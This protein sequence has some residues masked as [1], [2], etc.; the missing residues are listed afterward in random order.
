MKRIPPFMLILIASTLLLGGCAAREADSGSSLSLMERYHS[1]K[2]LLPDDDEAETTGDAKAEARQHLMRGL[3]FMAQDKEEL[4]FEQFSRAAALDNQLTQARFQRGLLLHRQGLQQD[5]LADMEAVLALEPAHAQACEVSG[6]IYFKAGLMDEAL[7]MF[8]KA[9]RLNPELTNSY[10]FI[11]ANRNYRKEHE[12]AFQTLETALSQHPAS[13]TLHNNMGMTLSM[14][15]R[16]A[17]A[18][19]HFRLAVRLG[20][21]AEKTWNNMGLALCRLNRLD[22]ALIAFRNAG[23]EASAHNNVGYYLFLQGRY[24]EAVI[25]LEKAIALEPRYYARAAENLKRAQLA[26]RFESTSVRPV[27][28]VS[29]LPPLRQP[30]APVVRAVSLSEGTSAVTTDSVQ[31]LSRGAAHMGVTG[32]IAQRASARAMQ[33]VSA[34]PAI[35]TATAATSTVPAVSGGTNSDPMAVVVNAPAESQDK[36]WA[37]HESSWKSVQRANARAEQLR[38]QGYDARV[39]TFTIKNNGTWHRVVFGN[40]AS[41]SQAN[42]RCEALMQSGSFE[43]LRSVRVP[44]TLTPADEITAQQL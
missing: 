10:A 39:A 3:S 27:S 25:F 5:A 21:P 12:L 19:T 31:R 15:Q 20:A 37:V 9:V 24:S 4:A 28:G 22:E 32:N 40:H 34:A 36:V 1:G 8:H 29:L 7:E 14:M 33:N 30:A 35:R 6:A 23:S 11:A 26:A 43:D 17:E 38:G 16:D 2:T 18:V 13:A 41:L 44:T 42:S